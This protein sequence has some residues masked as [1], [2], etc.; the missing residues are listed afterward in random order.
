[1]WFHVFLSG[2]K[3]LSNYVDLSRWITLTKT[4]AEESVKGGKGIQIKLSAKPNKRVAATEFLS[5]FPQ[6]KFTFERAHRALRALGH[7]WGKE[8]QRENRRGKRSRKL[9][10]MFPLSPSQKSRLV[11]LQVRLRRMSQKKKAADE[12]TSSF[13]IQITFRYQNNSG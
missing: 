9:N 3:R 2:L 13:H 12:C 4:L 8:R 7:G 1:M 10:I 6:C 11:I 5:D